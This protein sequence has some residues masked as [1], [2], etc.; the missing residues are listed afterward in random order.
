MHLSLA[1][2]LLGSLAWII[3]L[4]LGQHHEMVPHDD[5][6]HVN[7]LL[8]DVRRGYFY[9]KDECD[10]VLIDYEEFD[11]SALLLN[12]TMREEDE[13][14]RGNANIIRDVLVGLQEIRPVLT[15]SMTAANGENMY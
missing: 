9:Y 8:E 2:L 13:R 5:I 14:I 15:V 3:H 7:A 11:S 1:L 4:S 10:V 6:H 12:D